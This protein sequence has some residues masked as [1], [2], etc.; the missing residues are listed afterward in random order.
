MFCTKRFFRIS[1]LFC[2]IS[3]LIGCNGAVTRMPKHDT[4]EV[5]GESIKQ[6]ELIVKNYDK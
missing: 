5:I 6:R 3:I 4:A 2:F 1:V